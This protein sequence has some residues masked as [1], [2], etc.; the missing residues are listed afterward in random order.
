MF[1]ILSAYTFLGV[2]SA[3]IGAI[4][5]HLIFKFT[6]NY[7]LSSRYSYIFSALF[8]FIG[9]LKYGF[10][11]QLNIETLLIFLPII[12]FTNLFILKKLSF[13][14]TQKKIKSKY[15][16]FSNIIFTSIV[17]LSFYSLIANVV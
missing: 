13:I 15:A 4:F 16:N 3:M 7:Y 14:Y 1:R 17:N 2:C 8:S 11:V 10:G 5:F 6:K 9:N 12:V